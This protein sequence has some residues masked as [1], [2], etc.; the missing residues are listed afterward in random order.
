MTVNEN[1]YYKELEKRLDYYRD[2]MY[3][4]EKDVKDLRYVLNFFIKYFEVMD[5]IMEKIEDI[6]KD[7]S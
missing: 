7:G 1:E 6:E 3:N 2:V 5:E 4:I